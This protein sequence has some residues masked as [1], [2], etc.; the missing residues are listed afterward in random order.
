MYRS[1]AYDW[2][3]YVVRTDL[4]I[5]K[6]AK[7]S[8]VLLLRFVNFSMNKSLEHTQMNSSPIKKLF[9]YT[10]YINLCFVGSATQYVQLGVS[11]SLVSRWRE[12]YSFWSS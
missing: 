9:D 7:H 8:S 6:V 11:P 12:G 2:L 4:F 5:D 1:F 10:T 3:S